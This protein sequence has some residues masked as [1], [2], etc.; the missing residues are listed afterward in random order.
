MFLLLLLNG[1]IKDE[2]FKEVYLEGEP[3]PG[4]EI[5]FPLGFYEAEPLMPKISPDGKKLLFCAS[6]GL[7]E[8]TGLWVMEL[9]T[10][11]TTLLD[12]DGRYGDWSPDSEWIAFNIGTQIYKINTNGTGLTQ[13]TYSIEVA[14]GGLTYSSNSF[15]PDWSKDN[16]LA[17]YLSIDQRTNEDGTRIITDTGEEII[18]NI[19]IG[20]PD[21]HPNGEKIIGVKGIS[22]TSLETYFPIFNVKLGKM[23]NI[24]HGD[25]NLS[26]KFPKYSGSGTEISFSNSSGIY[27][28]N[29]DGTNIKKIIPSHLYGPQSKKEPKIYSAHPSWHPDG[30]HIVYEHFQITRSQRLSDKIHVEG[31]IRFYKV[32]ADS[33][34]KISNLSSY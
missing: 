15:S 10:Q 30:K 21:W 32:N 6:R 24:V 16:R 18:K 5:F 19:K 33:A 22:S 11:K 13:L 29:S 7:P 23:E 25:N 4:I 3:I 34:M 8:W 12:R 9:E 17:Y 28:M 20:E 27:V 1:C 31:Y 2:L 14:I 26:N